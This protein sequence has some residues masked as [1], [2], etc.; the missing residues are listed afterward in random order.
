VNLA[1]EE[2]WYPTTASEELL[3]IPAGTINHTRLYR[4]LDR[5][6]RHKTEVETN[7]SIN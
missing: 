4:C 5:L 3:R 2:R 1:L 7:E 6:I